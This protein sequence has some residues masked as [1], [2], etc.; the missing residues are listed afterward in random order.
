MNLRPAPKRMPRA[1]QALSGLVVGAVLL[2]VSGCQGAFDLPLPGGAANSGDIIRVTA[3]FADVLDLVPQSAVKVDQVTVGSVEKIELNGWTARVTLRLPKSVKLP[4]N[5][6]AELKQTSLLGEKYVELAAPTT[7][8]PQGRLGD[9]DNIPLAHTGRNPEV[10]EVL[11]A[12]SLLLNGGGVAQLKIIETELNNAARGNQSQIRDVITQLNTFIG[13]LDSQKSEIVRAIENIDTLAA[14]LAAQKEN[15]GKALD[16]LPGGLKVLADQR[17]QLVQMLQ[18]LSRL[19]AV[20]TQVIQQ[21][22]ADTAAN[23]RALTPI[24]GELTKA[25]DNLPKSLQ[26]LLTYPFS[27]STI[28]AMKGDYTNMSATL[29]LNLANLAGNMGLP[30]GPPT[31]VPTGLP[32]IPGLPIPTPSVS[33]PSL[34][35]TPSH[36]STSG[37]CVPGIICVGAPPPSSSSGSSSSDESWRSLYGGAA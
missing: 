16:A 15:I 20:G 18:A 29:D 24:L 26:L 10:E 12:M 23:L 31:G 6:V 37:N 14:K 22:K 7:T 32:T 25:G 33:V 8:A 19:G 21:S 4:D 13:G 34:P 2:G 17:Q 9:G 3:E 35:I 27:D 1:R 5:A 36:S 30:T 28:G 11:S